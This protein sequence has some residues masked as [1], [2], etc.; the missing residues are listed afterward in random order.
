MT[1][2]DATPLWP[3]EWTAVG[4]VALAAVTVAVIITTILITRQ[5][6]KRAD[7]R[8][9]DERARHDQE[10]AEERAAADKRLADEIKAADERLK[11]QQ[12]QSEE[13]FRTAQWRTTER[14]QYTEAYAVQVT[15]GEAGA[16]P[17]PENQYG[18][19]GADTEKILAA[20]VVNR[21]RYTI[22]QVSVVFCPDGVTQV[23]PLR[24][25]GL[26]G[27]AR[28]SEGVRGE[29][30]PLRDST[31]NVD[32]LAPWDDGIRFETNEISL[33]H[34][35]GPYVIVRWTDRWGTRWE[36]N[37]DIVRPLEQGEN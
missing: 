24:A 29:F 5:E 25:V 2:A 13:Q 37:K 33:S 14:E 31:R 16:S 35:A 19:P 12:E 20:M 18:D 28:L 27:F 8:L 3:A 10:I 17:G 11:A 34:I 9:A 23:L 21:G 32:T 1:L 22:T 26:A 4:T 30:R 7:Q 6:R 15:M 36:H